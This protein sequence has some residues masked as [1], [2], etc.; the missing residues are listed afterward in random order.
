MQYFKSG[1]LR[2]LLLTRTTPL[3]PNVP[4]AA[5][6]G[7]RTVNVSLWLGIFANSK[8]PKP[9]YDRL[10]SAVEAA[11]KSPAFVKKLTDLGCDVVYKNPRDTSK[12]IDDQWVLYDR[13]IK[14]NNIK[15]N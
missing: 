15:L 3:V 13:L 11:S 9:V 12:L 14:Q 7:L 10:V 1:D 4:S 2:P 8:T 5:D 6:L